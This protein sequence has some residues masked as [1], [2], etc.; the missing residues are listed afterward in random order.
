MFSI[1]RYQSAQQNTVCWKTLGLSFLIKTKPL[2][3]KLNKNTKLVFAWIPQHVQLGN[4]ANQTTVLG[5]CTTDTGRCRWKDALLKTF[6]K[7][8]VAVKSKPGY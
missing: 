8:L 6:E 1:T 4:T 7:R 3:I 2:L 5:G